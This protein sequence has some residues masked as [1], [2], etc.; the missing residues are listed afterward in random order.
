VKHQTPNAKGQAG[1]TL[2]EALIAIVILMFGLI[3]IANLFVVAASSNQIALNTTVA[4]A[5]ANETMERLMAIP[6]AQ[7]P[8][9]AGGAH[10]AAD[11]WKNAN[12]ADDLPGPNATRDVVVAGVLQFNA[13]RWVPGIG[14]VITRWKFVDPG[15]GGV[16]VRYILVRSEVQTTFGRGARAQFTTFRTCVVESCPF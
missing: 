1:F 16:P 2:V 5:E 8:T 6:F 11:P 9:N 15:A 3:A 4:A 7:L 14:M 10:N 12:W 13:R